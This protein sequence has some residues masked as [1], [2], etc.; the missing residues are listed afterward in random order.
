ML[1][2]HVPLL[3]KVPTPPQDKIKKA[4]Y[5][6][7]TQNFIITKKKSNCAYH[8]NYIISY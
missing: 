5:F 1:Q 6:I 3:S 8:M 7:P 2:S 4:E